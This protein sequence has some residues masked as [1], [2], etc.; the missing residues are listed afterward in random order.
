[1]ISPS[2]EVLWKSIPW[3]KEKHTG[4]AHAKHLQTTLEEIGVNKVSFRCVKILKIAAIVT[5]NDPKMVKSWGFIKKIYNHIITI[6]CAAHNLNLIIEW[7]LKLPQNHA[8]M[9]IVSHIIH[10]FTNTYHGRA[11]LDAILEK[12]SL[13]HLIVPVITRWVTHLDSLKR[14]IE[15]KDEL[16]IACKHVE[17]L[18]LQVDKVTWTEISKNVGKLEFWQSVSQLRD[19][20]EP[21]SSAIRNLEGHHGN[22][23]QVHF[24]FETML[25]GYAKIEFPQKAE[26][27]QQINNRKADVFIGDEIYVAYA[28]DPRYC[29]QNSTLVT[30]RTIEWLKRNFTSSESQELWKQVLSIIPSGHHLLMNT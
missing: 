15:R 9:T 24:E 19:I 17:D 18:G 6:G 22:I 20:L 2:H 28:L 5:D 1:M 11:T 13:P 16:L 21:I 25:V 14:L 7:L 29:H 3:E 8:L 4:E 26:L 30:N 27:L 10:F 12:N 23:A